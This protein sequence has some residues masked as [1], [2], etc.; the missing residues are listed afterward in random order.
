MVF[1]RAKGLSVAY[2]WFPVKFLFMWRWKTVG[3]L[4]FTEKL[5]FALPSLLEEVK[6]DFAV[7][8]IIDGKIS[9]YYWSEI[10]FLN[11]RRN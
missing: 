1:Y 8:C 3:T 11:W 6:K 7:L 4:S 2:W 10:Q 5:A 9:S